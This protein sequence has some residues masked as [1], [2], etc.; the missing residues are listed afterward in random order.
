MKK[1]RMSMLSLA[2][3]A[4][5]IGSGIA[6]DADAEIRVEATVHTPNLR[7]RVSS[8]PFDYYRNDKKRQF[9][10]RMHRQFK[11]SKRERMIARRLARYTGVP[12]RE[13]IQLRRQGYRWFEIGRWLQLPRP[14]VR[15]ALHR[16]S[17]NRF[18]REQRR[19]A[20]CNDGRY[21]FRQIAYFGEGH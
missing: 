5:L 12:S 9:P 8:T 18:L 1:M 7:V 10:A 2:T 3:L 20:R 21:R 6:Q 17:W 11:I 15:A 4:L 19:L 14:M 13:L 16:H